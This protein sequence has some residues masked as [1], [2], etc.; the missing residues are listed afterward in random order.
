VEQQGNSTIIRPG[1]EFHLIVHFR[2]SPAHLGVYSANIEVLF[3]DTPRGKHFIVVRSVTAVVGD[4]ADH[5][6][7]APVTPFVPSPRRGLRRVPFANVIPGERLERFVKHP[8][9]RKLGIYPLPRDLVDALENGPQDVG[10]IMNRLP[11]AFRPATPSRSNY[12]KTL[13]AQLW[14]EEHKAM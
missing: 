8:Y 6:A 10:K 4:V 3:E 5:D 1:L 12:A 7:L 14:A 11:A 9:K 13:S 2:P